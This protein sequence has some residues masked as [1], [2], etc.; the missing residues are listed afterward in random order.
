MSKIKRTFKLTHFFTLF[1]PIC[2]A[3]PLS[4]FASS[5]SGK[6]YPLI[7]FHPQTTPSTGIQSL[8][9]SYTSRSIKPK[10]VP[11][12]ETPYKV[13]ASFWLQLESRATNITIQ[14]T[15]HKWVNLNVRLDLLTFRLPTHVFRS[16]QSKSAILSVSSANVP[17]LALWH[18]VWY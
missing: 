1:A 17:Y 6:S 7:S 5:Y 12:V 15:L 9:A 4:N 10:G 13:G 18:N 11:S 3:R 16:C 2:A 14:K 8:Y